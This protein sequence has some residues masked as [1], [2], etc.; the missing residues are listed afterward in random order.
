PNACF[1]NK[2]NGQFEDITVPA[3]LVLKAGGH[4][5]TLAD[6]DG[7]GDLDLYIANY[8]ENSILR[9]GGQISIRTLPN[10][11]QV[12]SGRYASRVKIVDGKLMELGESDVLYLNDGHGKFKQVSWTDGAFLTEEGKPLKAAPPDLGLSA[13]FRDINGDGYPDLYVCNDF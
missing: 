4:S 7:D 5:L 1:L 2:G 13:M 8:G 10:G 11:K 3:G 12:V 6:I 9:S